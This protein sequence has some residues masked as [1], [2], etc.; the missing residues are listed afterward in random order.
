[1]QFFY[2]LILKHNYNINIQELQDSTTSDINFIIHVVKYYN[3]HTQI[4]NED[5]YNVSNLRPL[6]LA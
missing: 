4:D 2:I 6:P 5:G 3:I 1:M